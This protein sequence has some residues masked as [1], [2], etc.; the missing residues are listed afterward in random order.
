MPKE[1]AW[2]QAGAV[3]PA[4]PLAL[5]A[6]GRID[7]VSQTALTR[8]YSAAGAHGVAVGVHTTQFGLHDD[9]GMLGDVWANTAAT[10]A[11]TGR[12]LTLIAGVC[13]PLEQAVAE[14]QLALELGYRAALVCS[15]GTDGSDERETLRIFAAVGEVM[16]TIG[17]YLQ[18]KVGGRYLDPAFWRALFLQP[19]LV[20]VKVAPFDRYRTADVAHVLLE[21]GRAD[22]ALLTG[23]DDNIIGDLVTTFERSTDGRSA[24]VRF[25]G[26]LLG[27]WAIGTQAATRLS[28]AATEPFSDGS[29]PADLLTAGAW[30]TE[31]NGAVFDAANGFAGCVAGVN[32]TLRQQRLL[33]SRLCLDSGDRLSPGQEEAIADVRR[34]YPDML[35]EQFIAENLDAWR[36]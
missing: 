13:G 21:S 23:N 26:G 20:A 5:A 12:E 11:A 7:W 3:I 33:S 6:D 2:T 10:I 16:P 32:E 18:D 9:R 1:P 28:A 35:D 15:R 22:V 30:L 19:S 24:T 31:I 14:A 36:S 25:S 34:R 29:V 4:H 8:Y 17:F 27:Q